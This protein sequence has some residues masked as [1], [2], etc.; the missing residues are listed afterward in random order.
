M[1]APIV[2]SDGDSANGFAELEGC[3]CVCARM[4]TCAGTYTCPHACLSVFNC[5]AERLV[6]YC[7]KLESLV[8][9]LAI[10]FSIP[11]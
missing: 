1:L 2:L 11:I 5:V 7:E 6:Y 9:L 10:I 8:L 3:M 4:H